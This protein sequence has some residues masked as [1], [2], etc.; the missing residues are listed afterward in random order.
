M[1]HRQLLNQLELRLLSAVPHHHILLRACA[2]ASR[3]TS[4]RWLRSGGQCTQPSTGCP[5]RCRP[6]CDIVI[7]HRCADYQD[8]NGVWNRYGDDVSWQLPTT[9]IACATS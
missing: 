9:N 1:H 4:P 3:I 7:N 5:A 2:A 8:E 6:V